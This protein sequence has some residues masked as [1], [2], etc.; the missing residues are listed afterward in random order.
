MENQYFTIRTD[1]PSEIMRISKDGLWVHPDI[2]T[3]EVAQRVLEALDAQI[4]YTVQKAVE[5]EREAC[6]K[7]CE[8]EICSCCWDESAE[9]VAE[10]LAAQ[11]R[12]RQSL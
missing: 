6:A 10:H 8:E 7:V 2:P 3:D 12:A 1:E 9:A 11:I 5:A 4:K